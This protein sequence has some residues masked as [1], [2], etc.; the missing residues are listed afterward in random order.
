[1]NAEA[2]TMPIYENAIWSSAFPRNNGGWIDLESAEKFIVRAEYSYLSEDEFYDDL[3][4][5]EN[6]NRN[7][8][9]S[10]K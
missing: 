8:F 9:K 5:N 4:H 10:H 3:W 7:L 1:M 6:Y 2:L